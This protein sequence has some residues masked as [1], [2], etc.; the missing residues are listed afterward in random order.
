ML[1]L[2]AN[3][4][5]A[6]PET[7]TLYMRYKPRAFVPPPKGGGLMLQHRVIHPDSQLRAAWVAMTIFVDVYVYSIVP[8]MVALQ[9]SS[10]F[11]W[12]LLPDAFYIADVLFHLRLSY[13]DDETCVIDIAAIRR[14]FVCSGML[15]LSLLSISPLL[16][17]LVLW[18]TSAAGSPFL[19]LPLL[20][21]APRT[22]ARGSMS[23][24][25]NGCCQWVS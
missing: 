19:R 21:R 17:T 3:E 22:M 11:G 18:P 8:W 13:R 16:L 14:R 12:Y 1:W 15:V 10:G 9:G 23:L 20:F 2:S 4:S 6:L 7:A 24:G 25:L 5:Q